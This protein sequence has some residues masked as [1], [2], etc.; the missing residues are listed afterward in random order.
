MVSI[1]F[2]FLDHYGWVKENI[3]PQKIFFYI[4]VIS[5]SIR[6]IIFSFGILLFYALFE[7]VNKNFYGF[8]I[9]NT[10]WKPYLLL[11]LIVFPFIIIASFQPSFLKQY[12]SI[13]STGSFIN[14]WL[15]LVIYEPI[16]LFDFISIEWFFRGFLILGMVKTLGSK[17]IL[18]M[19]A[20][21][22]FF[23]IGKPT[24]EIIGSAF[25]GYILGVVSLY[26]RSIIGGIIIHMGVAFLMDAIAIIQKF[27]SYF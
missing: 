27:D 5:R 24:G 4:K 8:S 19:V 6:F 13:G 25:G 15:A 11:L 22:V 2:S 21:Y 9:K 12:P 10:Q 26:S 17:A 23:H 20:L 7:K 1:R 18:P 16:Y 14:K 3:A